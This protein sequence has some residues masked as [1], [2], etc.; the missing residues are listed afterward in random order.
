[1]GMNES[2]SSKIKSKKTSDLKTDTFPSPSV[3]IEKIGDRV[4]V[5]LAD[6]RKGIKSTNRMIFLDSEH[7][8]Q[9]KIAVESTTEVCAP[10]IVL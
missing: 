5:S 6:K 10:I 8:Y 3:I 7:L 2:F 4:G 9:T 1:M